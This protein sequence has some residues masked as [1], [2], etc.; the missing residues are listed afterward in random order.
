MTGTFSDEAERRA[1]VELEGKLSLEEGAS[2][3]LAAA[4]EE[5]SSGPE[6]PEE[7]RRAKPF[8]RRFFTP[9]RIGIF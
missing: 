3:A 9:P 7:T 8:D 5:N 2:G 4:L 1:E 6:P